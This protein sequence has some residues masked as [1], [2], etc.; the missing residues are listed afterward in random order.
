MNSK[1]QYCSGCRNDFY[2][3]SSNSTSGECWL[4]EDAEVVTRF[5]IGWWT[6][7]D[8]S[9]A[10]QKVTT[11][12]CHSAPGKYGHYKELPSFAKGVR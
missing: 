3:Q 5:R 10:F 2:N 4:L 1:K 9:G 8:E 11:L 6:R 12:S 7:P